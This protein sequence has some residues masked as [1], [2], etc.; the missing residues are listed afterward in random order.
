[1]KLYP[2]GFNQVVAAECCEAF[3]ASTGLGTSIETFKN[4][5]LASFGED[6]GNC[7]ISSLL[8]SSELQLTSCEDMHLYGMLQARRFGGKYIYFCPA[9]LNFIISPLTFNGTAV[10]YAKAGPFLMIER[11]DYI[12]YD[13]ERLLAVDCIDF[14][15]I[16]KSL[17]NLPVVTPDQV[18]KLSTLLFMSI[19][20]VNSIMS[21]S[22]R[23]LSNTT[24]QLQGHIG[25]MIQCLRPDA[26]LV[27][28][29]YPFYKE[30]E[31]IAA[32]VSGDKP[33]A[34]KLLNDLLGYIF[35]YSE[36]K[37]DII[38]ARVFELLVLISRGAVDGGADPQYMFDLNCRHY[39]EI[40]SIVDL[41]QLCIWLNDIMNELIEYIFR[42]SNVKH[43]DAIRK[44]VDYMRRNYSKKLTL[45][46]VSALAFLSP[47]YFS[48]V[49]K[50]E[51]NCNFNN[52]LNIIRTDKAKQLL[53]NDN[54]RLVDIAGVVGFED[55]SYFSKVFKRITNMTPGKFR[56]S[57]AN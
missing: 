51:M 53:M 26:H 16:K 49:F 25:D 43:A 30:S 46:E 28:K 24:A 32:I 14:E 54:I 45:E 7:K 11:D 22:D 6:C 12:K 33:A 36:G 44:A 27:D 8:K 29:E 21:K 52:Y 41:D 31:L 18:T 10:A 40:L 50:E 35:F 1:M 15:A 9:G 47:S 13:L 38:R 48:K 57:Q 19:S 34:D 17:E 20:Y 23:T 3:S 4:E 55:Q 56:E 37:Y 2:Y 5:R 39:T 42:F